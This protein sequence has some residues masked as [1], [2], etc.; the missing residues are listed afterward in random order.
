MIDKKIEIELKK[1]KGRVK[2]YIENLYGL[3]IVSELIAETIMND[4]FNDI[5][6]IE[7]KV[8]MKTDLKYYL[9]NI[10]N[11]FDCIDLEKSINLFKLI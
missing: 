11:V 7:V 5:E 8:N 1:N 10:L 3:P 6:L 2:N 4:N 9:L